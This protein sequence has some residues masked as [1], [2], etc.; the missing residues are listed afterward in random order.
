MTEFSPSPS[1]IDEIQKRLGLYLAAALQNGHHSE[2]HFASFMEVLETDLAVRAES[3]VAEQERR[4]Q[5]FTRAFPD[6][7]SELRKARTDRRLLDGQL[8]RAR[9]HPLVA[10]A[11]LEVLS[12]REIDFRQFGENP[13][14]GGVAYSEMMFLMMGID[15]D[16]GRRLITKVLQAADDPKPAAELVQSACPWA[17]LGLL[18]AAMRLGLADFGC[19]YR[20][21]VI[22]GEVG[23]LRAQVVA[24]LGDGK[25][26]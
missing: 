22:P 1:Q 11:Y 6:L 12:N 2:A 19:T 14:K 10:E 18:R 7:D 20:F 21:F 13:E 26:S 24:A 9:Q 17:D 25:C 16:V 8:R 15:D 5:V 23:R 4:E 3:L